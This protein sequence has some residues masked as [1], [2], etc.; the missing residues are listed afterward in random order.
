M[1]NAF[2]GLNMAGEGISEIEDRSIETFQTE[3]QRVKRIKETEQNNLRTE[4]NSKRSNIC[5]ILTPEGEEKEN[6]AREIFE[7][8]ITNSLPKL[9]TDTKQQIQSAHRTLNSSD[10]RNKSTN[11]PTHT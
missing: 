10:T 1:K 4:D 11:Q 6:R 3:K 9:M 5:I 7:A 8:I 2:S